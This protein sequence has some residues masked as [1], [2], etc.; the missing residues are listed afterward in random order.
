MCR[1][2]IFRFEKNLGLVSLS[3]SSKI[4]TVN[5]ISK[6]KMSTWSK[7]VKGATKTIAKKSLGDKQGVPVMKKSAISIT[8]L[9]DINKKKL[10]LGK[11]EIGKQ[12]DR[13]IKVSLDDDRVILGCCKLPTYTQSPFEAGP[14]KG[15]EGGGGG[16]GANAWSI[17][18][19][20]SQEQ[21]TE[22]SAFE[23]KLRDSLIDKRDEMFPQIKEKTK[24]SMSKE[25]FDEK[26]NRS[27]KEANFDKGYPATL[28]VVVPHEATD[29]LGK[30]LP[31][32]HI[33]TCN[34]LDD[35]KTI[36]K[37]VTGSIH[38]LTA[39]AAIVPVFKVVRGIYAG[40]VGWGM[41]LTL[42]NCLVIKNRSGDQGVGID[43]S[44]VNELDETADE[45]S[46]KTDPTAP[47]SEAGGDEEGEDGGADQFGDPAQMPAG[48]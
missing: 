8:H 27:A 24:K 42:E 31:M 22:F 11:V 48:Y 29:S 6:V 19:N 9:E 40:G 20:I 13:F 15:G 17:N 3:Q 16:G 26:F 47:A 7:D 34:M 10:G 33:Q 39:R 41:K 12:G 45:L 32:P 2:N 36:T 4:R 14:F 28:R 35:D 25:S 43:V 21:Y 38:D 18:V 37:R 1:R 23:D 46:M 30:P 5:T 44:E